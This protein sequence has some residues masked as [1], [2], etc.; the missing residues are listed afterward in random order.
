MELL[1][2]IA[3]SR[4]WMPDVHPRHRGFGVVSAISSPSNNSTTTPTDTPPTSAPARNTPR[5]PAAT[6]NRGNEVVNPSPHADF[7]QFTAVTRLLK[8]ILTDSATAGHRLPHT[9][10]TPAITYCLSWHLRKKCN[11]TCNR[12]ADHI[13]HSAADRTALKS[14]CVQHFR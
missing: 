8:D 12:V 3:V 9:L 7:G 10:H 11:D 4:H 13:T 6:N 5:T 2:D 14:W 1:D